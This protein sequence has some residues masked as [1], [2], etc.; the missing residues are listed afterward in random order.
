MSR[1]LEQAGIGTWEVDLRTY[2]L[3]LSSIGAELLAEGKTPP[4]TWVD[5]LALAHRDDRRRLSFSMNISARTGSD[6]DREFR[7]VALNGDVHWL[8]QR[9][10]VFLDDQGHPRA[11]RGVLLDIDESKEME[12]ELL[13]RGRTPPI[14][15]SNRAGRDDRDRRKRRHAVLQHSGRT[16]VW[17]QC[18]GGDRTKCIHLDARTGLWPT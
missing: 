9:G 17:L 1:A 5:L 13:M 12:R 2:V 15:P 11:C 14:H 3:T 7:A 16:A 4:A 6:F 18:V 8:R 10:G